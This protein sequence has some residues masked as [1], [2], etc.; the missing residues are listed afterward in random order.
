MYSKKCL[1]YGPHK[2]DLG[3]GIVQVTVLSRRAI[4]RLRKDGK[5]RVGFTVKEATREL[6]VTTSVVTAKKGEIL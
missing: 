1:L 5:S 4:P 2:G 3:D 6:D